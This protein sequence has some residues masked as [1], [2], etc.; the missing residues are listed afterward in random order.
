MTRRAWQRAAR[1]PVRVARRL[2][3][4]L[5]EGPGLPLGRTA[6]ARR[7]LRE[8]LAGR[9]RA[10]VVGP[11]GAVRQVLPHARLDVVGTDPHRPEVTVVSGASESD[12]LPRRWDCIVVTDPTPSPGR[13]L[14][15]AGASR[16]GCVVA[17][18]GRKGAAQ[19]HLPGL[20]VDRIVRRRSVEL[21]VGRVAP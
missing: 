10:L 1:H 20:T 19:P 7:A 15:V 4:R 13:L 8:I 3:H 21:V 2:V 5:A 18:V 6:A 9:D 14:A 16:P 17:L 11:P 12:S